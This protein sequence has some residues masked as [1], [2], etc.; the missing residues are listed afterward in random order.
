MAEIANDL[1]NISNEWNTKLLTI[2]AGLPCGQKD[3][4]VNVF[5][6]GLDGNNM[7]VDKDVVSTSDD[8]TYFNQAKNRPV[9]IK[10]AF[11]DVRDFVNNS[12]D[13]LQN[14]IID[15][16]TGLTT[17]QKN[18][19]GANVFDNT[20]VSSSTSLDGKSENNRLNLIQLANDIYGDTFSLDND[21]T[22]NLSNADLRQMVT[23]LLQLHNSDWNTGTAVTH[24][25]AFTAAQVD[26]GASTVQD[27]NYA[28]SPTH[29]QDDLNQIRTTIKVLKGTVGWLTA[30]TQLY[31]GGANT[32]EGLLSGTSG[33]GTKTAS[34]P[35]GYSYDNIDGLVTRLDAIRDYTGQNS[36][37]DT[38]PSYS[39]TIYINNG[40]SLET[41]IGKLDNTLSIQSGLDVDHSAQLAA[42]ELF[43][44]QNN[45]TDS[46]PSYSGTIVQNGEPLELA[47]HRLDVQVTQQSGQDI[48]VLNH[49]EALKTFTGQDDSLDSTPSYSSTAFINNSDSLETAI[50]KLDAGL[51]IASASGSFLTHTD[52]PSTFSGQKYKVLTTTS[53]EDALEF[54]NVTISGDKVTTPSGLCSDVD[55]EILNS[56]YGIILRAPNGTRYRVQV[57]NGGSL[58]TTAI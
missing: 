41:A 54:S 34:N 46:A 45:N 2:I 8:L 37:T 23:A 39:S 48:A 20:Q 40:D 33:T 27:D 7:W 49:L 6:N 14:N 52:T 50:G 36:H 10:E 58:T 3:T 53:G 17:D 35:W 24:T 15:Q 4:S 26:V 38:S 29:T 47:I 51:S 57:D 9:T 11:D 42:L 55:V 18:R 12:I 13:D 31:P 30:L 5:V 28:G 22:K 44:G 32:L 1:A 56:G 16:S 21:G 25:G 19:I 43:V